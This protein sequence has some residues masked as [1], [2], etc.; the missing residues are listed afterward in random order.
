MVRIGRAQRGRGVP[1]EIASSDDGVG[2]RLE[3]SRRVILAPRLCKRQWLELEDAEKEL[4]RSRY[5]EAICRYA[6]AIL[7]SLSSRRDIYI[8]I[9]YSMS[10]PL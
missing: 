6:T 8:C 7:N 4:L 10:E 9:A 2:F 3:T 1:P 5:N